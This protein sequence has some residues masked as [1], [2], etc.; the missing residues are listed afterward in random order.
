M[1]GEKMCS[2]LAGAIM[3]C[4]LTTPGAAEAHEPARAFGFQSGFAHPFS[5][6]D[7]MLAMVGVGIWGAVLGRPLIVALPVVFPIMMAVGG[8][9]GM[10]SIGWAPIE[11]G[12]AVSVLA[13]GLAIAA[14]YRAP[15]W[16]ACSLVGLFALCHGY[17]HGQELPAAAN[18]VDYSAGFILATGLLHLTG[19]GIGEMRRLE[20]GGALL[21]G[22]GAAMAVAGIVLVGRAM[23]A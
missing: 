14:A 4:A 19:I 5:G 12:I 1:R 13:L 11:L 21:R 23:G 17:A 18:R 3:A 22:C 9:L 8:V 20:H 6:F 15:V 16:A 2:L 7:H 10:A